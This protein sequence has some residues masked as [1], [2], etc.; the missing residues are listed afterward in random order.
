M[1]QANAT[2]VALDIVIDDGAPKTVLV[3]GEKIAW[4]IATVVGGSLRYMAGMP[5]EDRRIRVSAAPSRADDCVVLSITD[6]G[7]GIPRSRLDTLLRRD[8]RTRRAGGL[9][10]VLLHDIVVAHGG[11]MEVESSTSPHDHGTTVRVFLPLHEASSMTVR[12]S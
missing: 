2:G 5:Q 6:N 11:R 1:G 7:P 12:A 3:D 9:A 10:L 4:G 8:A